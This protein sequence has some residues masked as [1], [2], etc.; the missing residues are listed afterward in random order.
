[1]KDGGSGYDEWPW[2]V[3]SESKNPSDKWIAQSSAGWIVYTF[4][5]PIVIRGYGLITAGDF[6]ER[7]PKNW[8]FYIM[9]AVKLASVDDNSWE[10]VGTVKE[11]LFT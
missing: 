3:M 9:D 11:C 10:A 7:D 5:K 1:M 6:D 4:E 2:K 8:T